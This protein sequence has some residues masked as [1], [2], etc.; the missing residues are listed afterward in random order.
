MK[1]NQ[2]NFPVFVLCLFMKVSS[3]GYYNWLNRCLGDRAIEN[4]RLT[5][6]IREVF[7]QNSNVYGTRRIAKILALDN[8][9]MI[10][11]RIGKLMASAGRRS[12]NSKLLPIRS[13]MI[14]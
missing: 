5:K 12:V 13:I 14:P 3:G 8:I 10:R 6:S 9:L 2:N 4:Q 1:D 11:K 7:S